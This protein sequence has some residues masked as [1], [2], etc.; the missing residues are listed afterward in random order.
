MDVKDYISSGILENYVLGTVSSQEKQE[1]E[2]MSHIYPEIHKELRNIQ[3]AIENLAI[4]GAKTPPESVKSALLKQI[5]DISQEHSKLS[6]V[7][8]AT[9][10][11]RGEE[12]ELK[13]GNNVMIKLAVAASVTLLLALGVVWN[14]GNNSVSQLNNELALVK[15]EQLKLQL[16]NSE[17]K[18]QLAS[19]N[20][21]VEQKDYIA[22][23]LA[24]SA[25]KKIDLKGTDNAPE[26]A[27]R[28]YW[29]T[30][31]KGVF[32]K[33][34]DLPVPAEDKQFQLWAI[35]DGQPTDMGVFEMELANQQVQQMPFLASS[36]QAF[37]ITLEQKGG[38][39]VPD[40]SSL[41][42][43]GNI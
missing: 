11:I 23:M 31:T 6:V 41:Q 7:E 4:A 42:V 20:Q 35:I 10:E 1:V 33:V 12:K 28:V 3:E 43:I 40:L 18:K 39:K 8:S 13:K 2:C 38:S 32:L 37:A 15:G 26:S 9:S 36:A 22:Y 14:Q 19:L 27:V 17:Q 30:E 16:K 29:N 5:G 34:D 24:H 21:A 25:T